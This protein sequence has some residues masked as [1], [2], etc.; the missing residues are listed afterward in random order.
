MDLNFSVGGWADV[1]VNYILD[2]FTPALDM[3]AA[4]IGF[5]TDGIRMLSSPFRP[6]RGG[7]YPQLAG[8]VA[9][10]GNLRFRASGARPHHPHGSVERRDG[11]LSLVLASTVIAVVIG[12]QL[13]IAM[14]RE[15]TLLPQS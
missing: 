4:A 14:A 8:A 11:K 13:S 2:H 3:I 15:V 10:A 12:I 5:V 9:S 1:A 6:L 7:C